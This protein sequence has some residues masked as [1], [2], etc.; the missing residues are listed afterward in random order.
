MEL[1]FGCASSWE[2]FRGVSLTCLCSY[3]SRFDWFQ[4]HLVIFSLWGFDLLS[5]L[6]S[7]L[8]LVLDLWCCLVSY[9]LFFSIL[10]PFILLCRVLEVLVF[11]YLMYASWHMTDAPGAGLWLGVWGLTLGWKGFLAVSSLS[12]SVVLCFPGLWVFCVG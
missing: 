2:G 11:L 4:F 3:S 12:H 7:Y 10:A 5:P 8:I 6:F 1:S 9:P